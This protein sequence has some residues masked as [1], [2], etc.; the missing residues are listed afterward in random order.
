M[1]LHHFRRQHDLKRHQK[2]HTG[3]RPYVCKTCSRSFARLD[4]LNRHQRAE[5]ASAC[6]AAATHIQARKQSDRPLPSTKSTAESTTAPTPRRPIPQLHIPFPASQPLPGQV[7][8]CPPPSHT[9]TPSRPPSKQ[10]HQQH[11]QQRF[12]PPPILPSPNSLST[13]PVSDSSSLV[14]LHTPTSTVASPSS[15]TTPTAPPPHHHNHLSH[16]HQHQHH[17]DRHLPPPFS[18]STSPSARL[19]QPL[20]DELH[21]LKQRVHDLEVEN[22]VLRSIILES[23]ADRQSLHKRPRSS[24][25]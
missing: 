7:Y 25:P 2:L 13:L 15:A 17:H 8:P 16:L 1:C 19:S 3:E 24:S 21:T 5:G 11:Q 22:K 18:T 20:L 6:G 23:Q 14:P 12:S 4:A 10:Q 9:L